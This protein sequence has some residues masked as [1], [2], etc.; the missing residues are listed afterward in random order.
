MT[1]ENKIDTFLFTEYCN[2]TCESRRYAINDVAMGFTQNCW[3][4]VAENPEQTFDMDDLYSGIADYLDCYVEDDKAKKSAIEALRDELEVIIQ[5]HK[6][7][8]STKTKDA[9]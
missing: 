2:T 8:A 3:D 1:L 7:A 6:A 5:E 9:A 4:T